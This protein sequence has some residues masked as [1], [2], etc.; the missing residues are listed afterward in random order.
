MSH[1]LSLNPITVVLLCVRSIEES[2]HDTIGRTGRPR[3]RR[4]RSREQAIVV[5]FTSLSS[6][7]PGVYKDKIRDGLEDSRTGTWQAA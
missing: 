3:E 1:P 4:Q 5:P 6:S 7:L 2:R